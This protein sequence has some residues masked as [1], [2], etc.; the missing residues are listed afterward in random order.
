MSTLPLASLS[1][2]RDSQ[3]QALLEARQLI[4]DAQALRQGTGV[5]A[6]LSLAERNEQLQALGLT[7]DALPVLRYPG[8]LTMSDDGLID[9]VSAAAAGE[10]LPLGGHES[11]DEV[12][13]EASAE[14]ARRLGTWEPTAAEREEIESEG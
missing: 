1:V 4:A 10:P 8:F 7:P 3:R 12:L 2:H 5:F 13:A 11:G 6:A 14:L 9:I